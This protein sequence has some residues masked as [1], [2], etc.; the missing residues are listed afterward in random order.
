MRYRA[1][2]LSIAFILFGPVV[3]YAEVRYDDV[4][5]LD[6]AHEPTLHLKVLRRTPINVSRDPQSLDAY[7]AE[8]QT[9]DVIGLG[10]TQYYV[11]GRTATG[12]TEGWVDARSI[13]APPSELLVRLREH[14]E[15]AQTRRK[16]IQQHEVAVGMT[17]ADVRASLGKP[18]RITRVH[19]RQGDQEQWLYTTY[20]YTPLYTQYNDEIGRQRHVVS[21]HRQVSGHKTIMFQNNQVGEI[22][23]EQEEKPPSPRQPTN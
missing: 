16:L 2:F 12:L 1:L 10:E 4:I 20:Q 13:E 14:H 8:G 7:L 21:Y 9:V 15:E 18:D 3:L 11:S 5:Y 6:D 17:R 23:D 19:T 22:V